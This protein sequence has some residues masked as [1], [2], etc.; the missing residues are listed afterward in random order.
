MYYLSQEHYLAPAYSRDEK[1]ERGEYL[2][3]T[4]GPMSRTVKE[5][6]HSTFLGNQTG[7]I[8]CPLVISLGLD[9]G[10]LPPIETI[11]QLMRAEGFKDPEE[12]K[13]EYLT[14]T[15]MQVCH[16]AL[17]PT[18]LSVVAESPRN[19]LHQAVLLGLC[20][21][22]YFDPTRPVLWTS[23]SLTRCLDLFDIRGFY[24]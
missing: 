2:F 12:I 9:F 1:L 13:M 6:I 14:L 17:Y 20:T 5:K 22:T 4:G 24:L 7:R 8:R 19:V 23:T 3:N 18:R 11:G 15:G 21:A 10:T 16:P